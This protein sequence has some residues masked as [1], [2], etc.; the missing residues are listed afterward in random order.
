MATRSPTTWTARCWW[1]SAPAATGTR[2]GSTAD[3]PIIESLTP[4]AI[5]T[6]L[7]AKGY[8]AAPADQAS[9]AAGVFLRGQAAGHTS[10]VHTAADVPISAYARDE[11]VWRKFVGVQRNVDVFFKV[12]EVMG[13]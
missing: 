3:K 10:A 4:T 13:L 7:A 12:A 8:A 2:P 1:A 11:R 6:E 9:K 5:R